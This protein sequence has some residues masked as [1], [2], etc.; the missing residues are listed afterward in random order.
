[1]A[2][3]E[4][5]FL[6]RDIEA[7]LRKRTRVAQ[8]A[9]LPFLRIPPFPGAKVRDF[10]ITAT[11][12]H[13]SDDDVGRLTDLIRRLRVGGTYWA[14]RRKLPEGYFLARSDLA[15]AA[16]QELAGEDPVVLL[17]TAPQAAASASVHLMGDCD[18]WHMLAGAKA[19]VA[20]ADDEICAIAGFLGVP[21]YAPNESGELVE[22]NADPQSFVRELAGSVF[23]N[24]FT[25]EEMNAEEAVI[26]CG[27]WRSLIDSNRDL[28]GAIGFAFWKQENV[29]PLLWDGSGPFRFLSS[30]KDLGLDRPVA[31]WRSKAPADQIVRLEQAGVPIVE[32]EDGFLRSQGLGAD[33][34]PP[35]SITVDRL[36]PYFDPGQPSELE[37]LLQDGEF[38]ERLLQRA[39]NLRS[40]IVDAGLGKYEHGTTELA[41]PAAH[42]RHILVPGQVEDDRS[43]LTGGGGL[44][45]L[46]L[47]KLVRQ[48]SPDA[49]ILYKPHPDVVAGHRKGAIPDRTCLE[50]ADAIAAEPTIASLI[51]MVDEVHV[52]TSLAGFEA[53]L[54]EKPVTTYGVPFYA[55]WGLTRDKGAVPERRTATR[56]VDELIAATLLLYPRYLDPVTGLPCPAEVVVDRL[57]EGMAGADGPVVRLRRLQGKFLSRI[58]SV[59][60]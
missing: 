14:A 31:V 15:L 20:G 10:P 35:L 29:A 27:F 55:G 23:A 59:L 11:S 43:V 1:V 26:L 36:G 48:D 22:L 50:V 33:C 56:N 18:P 28:A 42:R 2:G 45:N 8:P 60:P 30:A 38:D 13:A 44:S 57:T 39:R 41:R 58:R 4:R 51:N 32:V 17:A 3:A 47:L 7:P 5:L 12:S 54:R 46:D 19:V 25:G 52:N 16:A 49:Y 40:L 34:V 37:T 24:P 6:Q 53:L 21:T 9:H